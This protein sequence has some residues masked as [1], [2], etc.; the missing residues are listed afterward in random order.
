MDFFVCKHLAKS[1]NSHVIFS[2]ISLSFPSKGLISLVG[3]SG[4]GKSTL[5]NC[6]L[7]IEKCEGE[8]FF[9][10]NK[11]TDFDK[12]RNKFATIIFQN[13]NLFEFLSVE[14]NITFFAK[15]KDFNKIVKL[16]KLEDKLDQ[17]VRYLSGGEKQRV[18]LARSLMKD[19]LIIFCDEV[20]GS[21]DLENEIII[22]NFL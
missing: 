21:L 9:Q 13:F 20:T 22:M 1:F 4:C 2:N 17:E 18:A 3:P 19:P 11:I 10:E 8:I 15:S 12:F 16:L 5:I 6:L 7:G 14:E